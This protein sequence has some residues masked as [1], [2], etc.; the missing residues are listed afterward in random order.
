[1]SPLT[2]TLKLLIISTLSIVCGKAQVA[3]FIANGSFEE[4]YSCLTPP[5]LLSKAKHWLAIDSGNLIFLYH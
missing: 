2:N 4:H 1:M 3:N 5:Y